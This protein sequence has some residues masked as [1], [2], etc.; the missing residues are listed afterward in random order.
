MAQPLVPKPRPADAAPP[1]VP[2]YT[3]PDVPTRWSTETSPEPVAP[4]LEPSD[5]L[6]AAANLVL[7]KLP[8]YIAEHIRETAYITN[9]IPLW[10]MVAGHL[11]KAF[12][13][14]DV[15]TPLMD[16]SWPKDF[17]RLPV[18]PLRGDYRC[19]QCGAPFQP[20]RYK[21]RFCSTA[22]GTLWQAIQPAEPMRGRRSA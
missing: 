17:P 15:H 7:S 9:R 4:R 18:D 20:K 8:P 2:P 11:Y 22:C 19:E 16:P 13:N 21:E 3:V 10:A 1:P 5:P 14:G 12:E 6:D